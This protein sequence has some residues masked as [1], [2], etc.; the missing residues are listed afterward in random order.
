MPHTY[1]T[2]E[3]RNVESYFMPSGDCKDQ[4]WLCGAVQRDH[5]NGRRRTGR[6]TG[7]RTVVCR[8][9][10]RDFCIMERTGNSKRHHHRIWVGFGVTLEKICIEI[11]RYDIVMTVIIWMLW[12]WSV[13]VDPVFKVTTL[14]RSSKVAWRNGFSKYCSIRKWYIIVRHGVI[15]S[16]WRDYDCSKIP[17]EYRILP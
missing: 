1:C 12:S 5:T 16:E 2:R 6:C 4:C 11:G 10:L 13:H 14:Y 3:W 7:S 8:S 9:Y 15:T 17:S